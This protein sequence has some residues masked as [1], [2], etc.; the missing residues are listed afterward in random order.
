LEFDIQTEEREI[1]KQ[2]MF[3]I[4]GCRTVGEIANSCGIHFNLAKKA[5]DLLKYHG[6][7]E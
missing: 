7:V 1:L 4:D 6:L 5:I 2:V 3:L